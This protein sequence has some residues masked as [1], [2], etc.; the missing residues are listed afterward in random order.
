MGNLLPS[1]RKAVIDEIIDNISTNTAQYYVYASN[2][3]PY[4]G[5]TPA[6]T[7]DDFTNYHINDWNM[8][9][10]K[11]LANVDIVP[12]ID[13]NIWV[14]NT[15]Y[16]KYDDTFVYLYSSNTKFYVVTNPDSTEIGRAHV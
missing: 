10:G 3:V 16:R 9:L 5:N 15:V 13:N 6:L 2:P 8:M 7:E 14:S 11:R 4:S 12:V 1:F